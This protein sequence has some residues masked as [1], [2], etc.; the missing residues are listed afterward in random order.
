METRPR[1]TPNGMP[2]GRSRT[3]SDPGP[4]CWR[5]RTTSKRPPAVE[6]AGDKPGGNVRHTDDLRVRQPSSVPESCRQNCWSAWGAV[7][8]LQLV[9][10]ESQQFPG[11]LREVP[12]VVR[13]G[14]LNALQQGRSKPHQLRGGHQGPT[15]EGVENQ[16]GA[17]GVGDGHVTAGQFR[18]H[19]ARPMP[20]FP[21]PSR[22]LPCH[23]ESRIMARA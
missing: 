17:M 14:H 3:R 8:A 6:L 7:S 1:G 13:R 5:T 11:R 12:A 16:S 22:W 15:A 18:P 20:V 4:P 23:P 9:G 10:H 19:A 2:F 21:A